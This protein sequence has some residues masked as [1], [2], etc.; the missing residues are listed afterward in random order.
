[1]TRG[2]ETIDVD[3]AVVGSGFGGALTALALRRLGRSVAVLERGRHPRFAIGESTTPLANLLL[4]ELADRHGLP[5]IRPLSKW[6]TWRR[7]YPEVACGLKRGFTFLR[8]DE[9]HAFADGPEHAR[10]LLVAASPHDEIADTHWYRPDFDAFLVREAEAEGAL[11]RDETALD[12]PRFEGAGVV[13]EGTRQGRPLRVSARF[14][15]D[16]SGPRGFLHRALGLREAPTRWLPP[17]EGLY[18]HFADVERWDRLVPSDVP[19]PYPADDA[20]VHHVF[21]GGWI[22]ILRFTNGITSAGAAVLADHAGGLRLR[23]GEPAWDRLL[24]RLPS[25]GAQ[26]ERARAVHPFV[27][28]PR[29]AF[30][31][32]TV[33]GRRWALLPSAAGVIDPLL[34]T[35][36]PLN[37]LGI[38]RLVEVLADAWEDPRQEEA[39]ARYAG[40]TQAELDATERLVAALYAA[41]PDFELFKRLSLLYFAAASFS[42]AARRLGRPERARGFLLHADPEF[43][44]ELRAC[45]DAALA[46]P[47]GAAREEL[48]MRIDA[49]IEPRDV[50]GL[51]DRTRC[52]HYPVRAEDLVA[53]APKLGATRPE[54]DRLLERSGFRREERL[55]PTVFQLRGP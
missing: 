55:S 15:V 25:V 26:F 35:G 39:L 36:F 52:D 30:R 34:S 41:M 17:T 54:I 4:E 31:T 47:Q 23:D 27:H 9:G 32:A 40:E 8:H 51:G 20:A 21:P 10:Q 19:P 53:G 24:S 3:V 7:A 50:A 6:G 1:M 14:L 48:L 29:V 44:P 28:A 45:C 11:Y 33:T 16:A 46:R 43:G 13:L 12:A 2:A 49:A 42:E 18:T 22:W 38:A 5:R 37:L